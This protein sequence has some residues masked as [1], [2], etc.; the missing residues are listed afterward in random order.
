MGVSIQSRIEYKF[1][2]GFDP[3]ESVAE[4]LTTE[5]DL[6]GHFHVQKAFNYGFHACLDKRNIHILCDEAEYNLNKQ[7]NYAEESITI[8]T[9]EK[10]PEGLPLVQPELIR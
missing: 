3:F 6:D 7:N 1:V 5:F 8:N 10:R 9:P 4:F 2:I